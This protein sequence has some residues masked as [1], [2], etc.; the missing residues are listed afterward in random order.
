[1]AGVTIFELPHAL[2]FGM[3]ESTALPVGA[4]PK[5]YRCKKAPTL[6]SRLSLI[7]QELRYSNSQHALIFGMANPLLCQ[8]RPHLIYYNNA[9]V[10]KPRHCCRGF[11]EYGR[12]YDIR[13]PNTR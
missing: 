12:S 2:I 5:L 13:T 11:L 7:W 8:L 10:K 6:L 1:M 9:D 3:A 4:T